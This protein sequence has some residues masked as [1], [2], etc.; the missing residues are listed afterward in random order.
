MGS[1]YDSAL[2]VVQNNQANMPSGE[3]DW[4][5]GMAKSFV[6]GMGPG[7]IG[8]A[9]SPSLERWQAENPWASMGAELASV[10]IPYGG[11]LGATAKI[12]R[13][14]KMIEGIGAGGKALTAPYRTAALQE[15]VRWTPFEAGRTGL[16]GLFGEDGAFQDT[17]EEGLVNIGLGAGI[18]VLAKGL[19]S[20]V[21]DSS[22][23]RRLQQI[24]EMF[25]DFNKDQP[26]QLR[27]RQL[28]DILT[29]RRAALGNKAADTD[30]VIPIIQSLINRDRVIVRAEV[31]KK[32]QGDTS[33]GTY[34]KELEGDGDRQALN[35]LFYRIN[36]SE[37][38]DRKLLAEFD[39]P[40]AEL[41]PFGI[42]FDMPEAFMQF[43]RLT[44]FKDQ[45]HAQR[46]ASVV[47]KN[48]RPVGDTAWM[49]KEK[50]GL[51][52]IAKRLQGDTPV[53]D[54]W[55]MFKT[56]Q[57]GA[58]MPGAEKWTRAVET[59]NAWMPAHMSGKVLENAKK[60][61]IYGGL[62]AF[63]E[64]L[65]FQAIKSLE[66]GNISKLTNMVAKAVGYKGDTRIATSQLAEIRDL[67]KSKIAPSL[68][69]F[70]HSPMARY[71]LATARNTYDHASSLSSKL[72]WGEAMSPGSSLFSYM[73]AS[74][75]RKGG[76]HE[77]FD[78]LDDG[79]M[80][81]LRR[82]WLNQM[83]PEEAMAIGA[84]DNVVEF[85]RELGKIDDFMLGADRR[86]GEGYW[87]RFG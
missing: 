78:K 63:Q 83:S 42:D 27:L 1:L 54:R 12:P 43:P 39:D 31:S 41:K 79:D 66:Q 55:L 62:L 73:T 10:A 49:G 64:R 84:S 5:E 65:P 50:D 51:Y 82:A 16:A 11:W 74:P 7:L 24:A 70:S 33:F 48:L 59:I 8:I 46:M 76:L 85:M 57:P 15:V 30:P 22:A 81:V 32:V 45:G 25:P 36:K 3:I 17:L 58:F 80:E 87:W 68:F 60:L 53:G 71:I 44:T 75:V 14:A 61:N 69:Q 56:D 77:F 28:S 35:R 67:V 4:L 19:S 20:V 29:G 37:G 23:L 47:K 52:V 34:L 21:R 26:A 9:P 18:G 38:T 40:E 2:K 6:H 13:L 72:Y 86:H